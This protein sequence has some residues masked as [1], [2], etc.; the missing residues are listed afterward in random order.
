MWSMLFELVRDVHREGNWVVGLAA[1]EDVNNNLFEVFKLILWG[2][3]EFVVIRKFVNPQ[4]SK[5]WL[6]LWTRL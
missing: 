6:Q 5:Q 3:M 4:P 1:L 2:V